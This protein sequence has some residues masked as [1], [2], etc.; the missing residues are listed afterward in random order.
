M[1]SKV[2]GYWPREPT[3][4]PCDELQTSPWMMMLVLL[5][6]KETQSSS[7]SRYEFWMT[8]LSERYVSQPSRL[9]A[10]FL[11]VEREKTSMSEMRMSLLLAMRL[12]H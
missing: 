4:M 11:L 1:R 2:P 3:E 10:A 7:W 5:G 12:C 8:M 9:L 6:L